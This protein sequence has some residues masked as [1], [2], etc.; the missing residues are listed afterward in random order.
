MSKKQS[1][2]QGETW[3]VMQVIPNEFK[4]ILSSSLW[5]ACVSG[6]QSQFA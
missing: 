1:R 3:S 4:C 6:K 5:P 2:D